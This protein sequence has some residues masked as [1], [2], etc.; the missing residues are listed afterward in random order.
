MITPPPPP[1]RP[2]R[3]QPGAT[4]LPSRT[5]LPAGLF[6]SLTRLMSLKLNHASLEHIAAG[7]FSPTTANLQHLQL[8]GNHLTTAPYDAL[9]R[10]PNLL[11]LDLSH[12]ALGDDT[13]QPQPIHHQRL[14]ELR[15]D[16]CAFQRIPSAF[17]ADLPA[18]K[19]LHLSGNRQL[20][21]IDADA[22]A[23]V[24][25]PHRTPKLQRLYVIGDALT[26]LDER[27]LDWRMLHQLSASGNAWACQ[28][29]MQ[30]I[31]GV[32]REDVLVRADKTRC[33]SPR[34][35]EGRALS[36]LT[37]GDMPCGERKRS[38]KGGG[39]PRALWLLIGVLVALLIGVIVA[40]VLPFGA[41]E[42]YG[43]RLVLWVRSRRLE[44]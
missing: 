28:C 40:S 9:K 14:Q 30:W 36:N 19:T 24:S 12:N 39:Q 25:A 17:F 32:W 38:D 31:V 41:D 34:R 8:V 33:A 3:A 23:H 37:R 13:M 2:N 43:D 11:S 27:L 1:P 7:A 42:S 18:L 10:L 35:L 16:N 6:T 22:F 15:L 29:E 26:K 20:W 21:E 44:F 5:D 4:P